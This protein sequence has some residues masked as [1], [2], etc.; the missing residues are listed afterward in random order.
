ME[1]EEKKLKKQY[2]IEKENERII[3]EE[4]KQI[5]SHCLDENFSL[6]FMQKIR[7]YRSKIYEL[8]ISLEEELTDA[9]KNKTS[10]K[11]IEMEKNLKRVE[12]MKNPAL[13]SDWISNFQYVK[14]Y[15]DSAIARKRYPTQ[16]LFEALKERIGKTI[17]RYQYVN[18]EEK[19]QE[20]RDGYVIKVDNMC[21]IEGA[22]GGLS[23]VITGIEGTIDEQEVEKLEKGQILL[24]PFPENKKARKLERQTIERINVIK[25]TDIFQY[26]ESEIE[27]WQE[28]NLKKK[29]EQSNRE[30]YYE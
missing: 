10:K 28:Q 24:K 30:Y 21:F 18:G 8:K 3:N 29:L 26:Y 12:K 13:I 1:E 23:T 5:M 16:Q 22:V 14:A 4:I 17:R 2:Q 25:A 19:W 6:N 11:L 20:E 7:E 9:Y 27:F 15:C